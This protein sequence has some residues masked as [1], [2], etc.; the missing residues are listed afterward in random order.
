MAPSV[1]SLRS[2]QDGVAHCSASLALHTA[3]ACGAVGPFASLV[4]R[5]R[6]SL[7]R[8]SCV[9][10]G[11]CLWRR[12]SLRFARHKTASLIAS[13]LWRCIPRVPVAPSVPSLRSSQDG[14]AHCFASLALQTACACGAVGPFASLVTRRRRSLL[15]FSCVAYRVCLWRRRSLRFARHMTA[16]LIASLLLRCKRR[17]P[18]A[19]SVPS[20]RSS[21]DGVAHYFASRAL[22]TACACGAVGPLASLV[23][24]RRRSLLRF[25]CVA[26]RVCLWRRR[27]LRF[28]RHRTAS[29]IA[30]LLLRCKRRVPVAPSVPSLRSSQDGVAHCFASRA[31]HTACACGAVGPFASLV[32]RRRR[33][34]LRFSCAAYRVCLWRRRSLRFARHRTASL[35]ASLLLRC[36]PRVPVAPLVPSLRS[37]HDGVA[38][39][40]AS[41]ALHTACAC[42]AVGPFAS[43]VTRRRR[44]SL[45]FSCVAYR[46]CLWRRRSL[47]FARHKTASLIASLLVRCIPRVPV[48]PSVP[49]LRSSQDGVA[50]CFASLALHTAC[51]CSAVGPFA[52]LVTGRRRSLLRF[53]C[54]ANGVCLWRRRSLR[55][56]RHTTASLIASLLVRCIPRVPVAPS[57]PSLR[58]S[59]DGVAHCFASLALHTVCACGAVGP[60]A[61]LVTGRRRSLLR[62]SCVANG[63][64]LWRRRSLR[65]ARHKTASLIASLLV[66]CIPRVPVAPSVPSLRSSQDG[67]AHR[68][69]S[70]ALHTACAC[71]AVGPFASLVTGRRRSLLRFSCDAY[72]VCLRRRRSLRFARHTTASLI[73]SLLWRC[74]PRVP[75]APSV[76]SLRS[77][78]DGVAHRFA[79]RALHTACAC[80]AVGPF[81]SLVTRRRRSLLRFSCVAY[82]VCL[83]RRRSL[84]FARHKT[85]S[86]IASLLLRCIPRVPVAPSVPSLRSSQD[87]VAHCFASLALQTA[88]ACGAV[89]PFASLVTR[90]RRSLLRFSCVAY[91]VCLWRR[92]SLRFA[93]HKTASLIASL[94]LR[95]IPRVPVAPSVPSLR[96]SQDGVAHCFASLALHT[97][98]ACGAVGPFA[99]LVTRRRRSLLRFS[100]VAYRVC[101]WRRR[102]L[103]FARHKTASLIA[104]LL[105]RCIP[106][107]PVAPSVPSLRSSQDGVAHCFASRALHTACACGAV[108]P[109]ASLVTRRRRSLL[110]FSCVAYRVCL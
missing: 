9:A 15:R 92:R 91:R 40:F 87:G 31:L 30:S 94:L 26:Y 67:V 79:S 110:R 29:L 84:R 53:S 96:S 98:C 68:F 102:S 72:R 14:V 100:C 93:R 107:V 106:R 64:C 60:F 105:V 23:T 56:A 4:T 12:R 80:G 41:L 57:V 51:A 97:A 25:S 33:S 109:F 73:A 35:I 16:L 50:H 54:V 69:A 103:R 86:L 39:C 24:R 83:W 37:S 20:L 10:N 66:R 108:G 6:C 63:V 44:S 59:Q 104:S 61:S 7:L 99:S 17:V 42:G 55:F 18:V 19:P 70:L 90:R 88:C 5:R 22:H 62:F 21:Q 77:S 76:P 78:Q 58:S 2:S 45:R 52:S 101:L 85:A 32:T 71:G 1:P 48:A 34:S 11:V 27:S 38:H 65:F 82:R 3:C 43:L 13:L 8:F 47:R 74:I 28:A 75:V 36:I 89:G 95:C 81:A 46:V 49:S